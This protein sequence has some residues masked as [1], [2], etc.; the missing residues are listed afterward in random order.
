MSDS[1]FTLT[2][3]QRKGEKKRKKGP[4]KL[5]STD[6]PK[7]FRRGFRK[8]KERKKKQG[9]VRRLSIKGECGLPL[10]P[11]TKKIEKERGGE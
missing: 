2:V 5:A 1:I 3:L 8:E 7:G 10:A 9:H 6:I 11:E 4:R